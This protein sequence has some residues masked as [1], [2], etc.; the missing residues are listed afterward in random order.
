MK[1]GLSIKPEA[2]QIV[3]QIANALGLKIGYDYDENKNIIGISAY[4]GNCLRLS[5]HCTYLQTWVDAGTWQSSYKYDIVIEDSP[6][7]AKEQVKDGYDFTVTEF[8]INT[9]KMNVEKAKIIAYDIKETLKSGRY[10]N[11]VGAEKRMLKSYHGQL[12]NNAVMPTHNN[13][14]K[15][16]N[17]MK[18]NK[19]TITESQLHRI[20]KESINKVLKEYKNKDTE[21][22]NTT[23]KEYDKNDSEMMSKYTSRRNNR[24]RDGKDMYLYHNHDAAKGL[25]IHG[26]GQQYYDEWDRDEPSYYDID[27]EQWLNDHPID[28][29]GYLYQNN[30]IPTFDGGVE[31][32]TIRDFD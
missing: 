23:G 12:T 32:G 14:S 8:V 2:R 19:R 11:N 4:A 5:D 26:R 6:T 7:L 13:E 16:M 18:M 24:L 31:R 3:T 22:F 20:I 25:A 28:P 17:Y 30:S 9:D 1:I 21:R 15:T 10:A 29:K 27:N